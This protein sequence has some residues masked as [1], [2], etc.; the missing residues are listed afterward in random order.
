M[1]EKYGVID[2]ESLPSEGYMI[3]IEKQ[4]N[5]NFYIIY[6]NKN[7]LE[8]TDANDIEE[9]VKEDNFSDL[10]NDST[11]RYV[12]VIFKENDEN[13]VY[14]GK[15][16]DIKKRL[17]EHMKK[18]AAST[19]SKLYNVY[20]SLNVEKETRFNIAVLEIKPEKFYSAVEGLL[21]THYGTTDN[22]GWN[23]RDD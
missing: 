6:K 7:S 23:E 12:Y 16:A 4:I 13:P 5:K 14:V 2:F 11:C 19:Y 3:E 18:K 10:S 20:K 9:L 15:T 22:G 8:L 1:N 21:I 17:K